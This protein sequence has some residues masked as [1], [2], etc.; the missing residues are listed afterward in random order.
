MECGELKALLVDDALGL[1]EER[2]P[3]EAHRHLAGCVACRGELAALERTWALLG[4][5]PDAEITPEFRRRTLALLED[6]TVRARVRTFHPRA[7]GLRVL[8]YAAGLVAAAALGFWVARRPESVGPGVAPRVAVLP[9]APA[10]T[11]TD[12]SN[13]S[14][15]PADASGRIGI[16]YDVTERRSVA[17]RPEDPAVARVLASLISRGA[18]TSGEKARAIDLVSSQFAARSTPAAEEVVRALTTTLRNDTNPGVRKKAADALA[19]LPITPEIR[20]AFFDAL[21]SDRNP[22]VR[23]IAIEALSASAKN[24]PDARTIESL[25]EKAVDPSENGFVRAKAAS[26]LKSI[27]F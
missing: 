1:S 27:E 21:R 10:Q 19:G 7:P 5:D 2:L 9:T 15:D 23:L 6:E 24:A 13:V 18:Q 17:G 11:A 25:R 12:V 4:E 22:A 16:H 14:F 3:E 26:A 20:A 8:A